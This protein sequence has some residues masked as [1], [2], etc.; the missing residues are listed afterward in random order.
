MMA[1]AD[2][3]TSRNLTKACAQGRNP[4]FLIIA[5]QGVLELVGVINATPDTI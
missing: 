4:I 3:V 5:G 1:T 2:P